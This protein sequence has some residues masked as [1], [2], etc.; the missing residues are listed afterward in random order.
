MIQKYPEHLRLP[1]IIKYGTPIGDSLMIYDQTGRN[2]CKDYAIQE[3]NTLTGKA[4]LR[5][6]KRIEGTSGIEIGPVYEKTFDGI[7]FMLKA[8]PSKNIA[9]AYIEAIALAIYHLFPAKK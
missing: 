2:I 3:I 8:A 4:I 9:L 5:D 6:I 7:I 1:E